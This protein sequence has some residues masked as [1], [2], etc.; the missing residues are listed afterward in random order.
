MTCRGMDKQIKSSLV[1]FVHPHT[2]K[3]QQFAG[4][5]LYVYSWLV[6]C[7]V[8]VFS[9]WLCLPHEHNARLPPT[10]PICLIAPKINYLPHAFKFLNG[11]KEALCK[12]SV[13]SNLARQELPTELNVDVWHADSGQTQTHRALVQL[14]IQSSTCSPLA[15]HASTQKELMYWILL[16]I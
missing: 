12:L 4:M 10:P 15:H 3:P 16:H 6:R 9:L 11:E 7:T 1:L 14:F 8:K 13:L 5:Y 2:L